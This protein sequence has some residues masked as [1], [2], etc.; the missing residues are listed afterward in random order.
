MPTKTLTSFPPR[1]ERTRPAY[2]SASHDATCPVGWASISPVTRSCHARIQEPDHIESVAVVARR[3]GDAPLPDDRLR[4]PRGRSGRGGRGGMARYDVDPARAR[5]LLRL[6]SHVP[7]HL[8][9]RVPDPRA[10]L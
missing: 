1:R 9:D 3:R 6:A 7:R 10:P 8:G 2:S 5:A 4:D